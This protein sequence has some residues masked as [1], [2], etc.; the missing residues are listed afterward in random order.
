MSQLCCSCVFIE[1]SGCIGVGNLE[2]TSEKRFS[3]A[4]STLLA[5]SVRSP[6]AKSAKAWT[7]SKIVPFGPY[8]QKNILISRGNSHI[9][10][11]EFLNSRTKQGTAEVLVCYSLFIFVVCFSWYCASQLSETKFRTFSFARSFFSKS[12]VVLRFPALFFFSLQLCTV[13]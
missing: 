5:W 3:G 4:T 1:T 12:T 10:P 9:H 11:L 13:A 8:R 6:S 7:K 2:N